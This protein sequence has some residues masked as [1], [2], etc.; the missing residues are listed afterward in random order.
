MRPAE[1]EGEHQQLGKAV[2]GQDG[3]VQLVQV[4]LADEL[5]GGGGC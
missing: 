4:V 3:E 1:E 2:S 5:R